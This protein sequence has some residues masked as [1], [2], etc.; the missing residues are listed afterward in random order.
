MHLERFQKFK[1]KKYGGI[2]NQKKNLDYQDSNIV[3]IIY[4]IEMSP[5]NA[6][7]RPRGVMIKALDSEI[8]VNEFEFYSR[9][10]VYFRTNTLGEGMKPLILTVIG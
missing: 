8:V 3:K 2:G 9:Y 5:R 1:V 4:N 6:W 10:N 7:G